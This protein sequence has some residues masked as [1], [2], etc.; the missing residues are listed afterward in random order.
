MPHLHCNSHNHLA[1]HATFAA[2]CTAIILVT[3]KTFAWWFSGSLTIQASLLDSSSDL[4]SSM[5]NFFAVRYARKP[6]NEEYRF[7]YGKAEALAGFLQSILIIASTFWMVWHAYQHHQMLE[8][9]SHH[10]LALLVMA[11][12]TILTLCLVIFQLYTIKRTN[13]IAVKADFLHYQAD[14]LSNVAAIIA[15]L[16]MSWFE[17]GWIDTVF[18]VGIAIFL[19]YGSIAILKQSFNILM[20][21]ELPKAIRQKIIQIIQSHTKVV[22]VHELR[23]RSAGHI[24]FIQLH[25]TLDPSLSLKEA[26]VIGDEVEQ[27]LQTSY[28]Q[29]EILIHLDPEGYHPKVT[30][31]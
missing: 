7:G 21:K 14:L 10:K 25:I 5:I 29:S 23:T 20:D 8:K 30:E 17:I 31:S 24:D 9:I 12:S 11:I 13:S 19:L 6:A 28:P 3:T 27:T 4:L 22:D 1:N 26:H 16:A 15:L 18:G 2:V